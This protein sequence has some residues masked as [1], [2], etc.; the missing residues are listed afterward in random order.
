MI[1]ADEIT[2]KVATPDA[3]K[4][5]LIDCSTSLIDS[6]K[7]VELMWIAI[8]AIGAFGAMVITIFM[9]RYAW[10][11]WNTSRMQLVA[12]LDIALAD[13]RLKAVP[14]FINSV[15]SLADSYGQGKTLEEV[16]ELEESAYLAGELWALTYPAIFQ[17]NCIRPAV[18]SVA[19]YVRK[20]AIFQTDVEGM[21]VGQIMAKGLN[22]IVV[23][24]SY[25]R[26]KDLVHK[27]YGGE[28]SEQDFIHEYSRNQS[29]GELR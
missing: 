20:D 18:S 19:K 22:E 27:L 29:R 15:R 21:D 3:V 13:K 24:A 6:A 9:A 5:D 4:V 16:I 28:I 14:E 1:L 26:L 17:S 25:G 2:C 7:G 23:K 8:G 11:A 10:K 12:T